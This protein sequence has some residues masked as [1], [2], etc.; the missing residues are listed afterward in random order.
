M[1]ILNIEDT[2]IKHNDICKVLRE[3]ETINIDWVKNLED[4]LEKIE[5]NSYDLIITDMYYPLVRGG[6]EEEAGMKLIEELQQLHIRTPIIVC[7]SVKL[8]ISEVL[9]TICYS[10]E[11]NWEDELREMVGS[12]I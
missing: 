12:M 3:K 4:A 11:S 1:N 8:K 6:A 9:G 10:K 2:A 7:S 5:K